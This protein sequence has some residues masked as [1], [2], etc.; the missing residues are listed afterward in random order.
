MFMWVFIVYV[1]NVGVIL[2]SGF[3]TRNPNLKS[4]EGPRTWS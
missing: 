2:G 3:H 4:T 1:K